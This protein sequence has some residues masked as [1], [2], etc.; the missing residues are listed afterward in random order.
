[1]ISIV[2][3]SKEPNPQY[4]EHLKKSCGVKDV[5]VIP[6]KNN[7]ELSLAQSYN[8]GLKSAK[9]DTVV[10]T[11]DDV[12]FNTKSWGYKLI[13]HFNKNTEYGIIGLAGTDTLSNGVWW[14]KKENMLGRVYHQSEGK[15]WLSDY[16]SSFGN[17]V[18]ET[19]VVD[20]VFIGVR[21][22]RI[23]KNFNTHFDGFHFYDLPFCIDNH[24]SG[25]KVGVC[26]NIELT[27]FSVGQTNEQWK[28]NRKLFEQRYNDILPLQIKRDIN[29]PKKVNYKWKQT[30]KVS[31]II[32][33]KD[34]LDLLLPCL[35]SIIQH[36][37]Y[38]NYEIL[39]ADTGSTDQNKSEIK[40]YEETH[41]NIKMVEFD[42]YHFGKINNEVVG[43][44]E[45][46]E[47][48]LFC[49]NDVEFLNDVISNMVKT[50]Q[51]KKNVGTVG[52]RLHY[53]DNS[54]QHNGIGMTIYKSKKLFT[55]TH[56]EVGK[57]IDYNESVKDV[58][59]STAA[60][61]MVGYDTFMSVGMFDINYRHCFEDVDLNLLL[62][63][64]GL[65]NYISSNAVAYHKESQSRDVTET[66]KEFLEDFKTILLPK[67]ISN[68]DRFRKYTTVI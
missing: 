37:E 64:D 54:I 13:K 65:N 40:Q 23:V 34:K 68:F 26:T 61:L 55:T 19:V 50:Y 38:P 15:R 27:H 60:C 57:T 48:I 18:V 28:D 44:L 1:M 63:I 66:Q 20:G 29:I 62:R 42:Y 45:N 58:L 43:M 51:M 24:L 16:S 36:T 8:H 52:A 25:V 3:C 10:F 32:P 31:V 17:N 39:I 7:G 22:D 5:E 41:S 12:A 33:T 59:G 4:I 30:P 6:I 46:P 53:E 47:L 9:Y 14:S 2:F 56:L 49:N 11:H 35:D 67:F 21:K